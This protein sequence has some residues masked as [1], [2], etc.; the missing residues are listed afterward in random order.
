MPLSMV[1]EVSL[2]YSR[3]STY[4]I[5]ALSAFR[6]LLLFSLIF[7]AFHNDRWSYKFEPIHFTLGQQGSRIFNIEEKEVC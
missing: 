3:V 5:F 2:Y 7:H 1:Y 6:V 4:C